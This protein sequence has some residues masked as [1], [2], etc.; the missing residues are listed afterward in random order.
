MAIDLGTNSDK[1][2][3]LGD[4]ADF[5]APNSD[6]AIIA[7]ARPN[8]SNGY[9]IS[10]GTWS[11]ANTF[12]LYFF[13]TYN[14]QG[15]YGAEVQATTSP[16]TQNTWNLI[17]WRRL[18]GTFDV[19]WIDL[20]GSSVTKSAGASVSTALD[21][22]TL[23]ILCD[24]APD[25]ATWGF[26]GGFSWL[27]IINDAVTDNDLVALAKGIPL[28]SFPFA[29]NIL[30]IWHAQNA[31]STIKGIIK[32]HAATKQ[33][34]GY[35]DDEDVLGFYPTELFSF[36]GVSAAPPVANWGKLLG[37]QNNRLVRI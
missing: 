11:A 25:V 20:G 32:G 18:S 33:G 10:S 24:G 6:R 15:T 7:L 26:D 5:T 34:T 2:L 4:N 35:S 31:A 8:N 17:F 27:S 29:E 3:T 28:L 12:T 22:S 14:V 1:Y 9:L 13:N 30:D 21:G 37:F 36:D 23:N 19:G 16:L